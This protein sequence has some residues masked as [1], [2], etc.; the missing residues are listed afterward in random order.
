MEPYKHKQVHKFLEKNTYAKIAGVQILLA[1][2][3]VTTAYLVLRLLRD[4]ARD[5]RS[6]VAK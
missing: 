3:E 6:K 2:I 4:K 1:A 5:C